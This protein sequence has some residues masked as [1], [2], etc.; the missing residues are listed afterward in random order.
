MRWGGPEGR[1]GAA[2]HSEH[3]VDALNAGDG[4]DVAVADGGDGGYGPVHGGEVAVG[5][6]GVLQVERRD[7]GVVAGE[8]LQVTDKVPEAADEVGDEEDL[9]EE[10]PQLEQDGVDGL[11]LLLQRLVEPAQLKQAHEAQQAHE[12]NGTDELEGAKGGRA[13]AGDGLGHQVYGEGGE[14]V[15][16]EPAAQV[17][18]RDGAR[19]RDQGARRVPVRGAE[20]DAEVGEEEEVHEAVEPEGDGRGLDVE[21]DAVGDHDH[22]VDD[23]NAHVKIPSTSARGPPGWRRSAGGARPRTPPPSRG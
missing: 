6:G 10:G 19:P 16:G 15:D 9:E 20:V 21:A 8:D 4:H 14:E 7:P 17:L 13:V 11:D 22:A 12:A 3:C 23:E 5:D 1:D 18:R 2:Y